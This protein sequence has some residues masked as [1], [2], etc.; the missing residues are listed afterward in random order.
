MVLFEMVEF[1][2]SIVEF[3]HIPPP[4]LGSPPP[5]LPVIVAPVISTA[6]VEYIA[7]PYKLDVLLVIVLGPFTVVVPLAEI[8]P[9][10]PLETFKLRVASV[11]ETFTP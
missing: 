2:T 11:S 3:D 10:F 4:L 9:E 7:P 5:A 6:P 1:T 8:A